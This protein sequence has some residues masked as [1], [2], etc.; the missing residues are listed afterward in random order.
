MPA[1]KIPDLSAAA[2]KFFVFQSD[3]S[4]QTTLFFVI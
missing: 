1:D 3:P 2:V 4:T